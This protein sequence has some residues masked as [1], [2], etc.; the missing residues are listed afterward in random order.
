MIATRIQ[1]ARHAN[2]GANA[3]PG[4]LWRAR[5]AAVRAMTGKK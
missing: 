3:Y 5:A 4:N 1:A 2:E